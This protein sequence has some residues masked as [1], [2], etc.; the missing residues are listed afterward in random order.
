MSDDAAARREPDHV[1]VNGRS[2]AFP[3]DP[4]VVV[5]IDGSEPDYH[6]RAIAAGRMPYLESVLA[7]G[8]DLLADSVM[9]SFTNPNNLSIATGAPP[10]VHGICG[11][12]FFDAATRT[13]VMMNDPRFLRAPTIFS[14]FEQAGVDVAVVTA[15]DK[16]R[17]L[18][19][20]G[21]KTGICFSAE[22]ADSVTVEENGIADALSLTGRPLPSVY[23]A[24]LSEFAM[25]AG[26]E[27]MRTRRPGL[28]YLSLT[29]Y[30]QHKFAPGT[31]E[32]DDFY[33]MLDGYFAQLG[34]L[35]AV[36]AITGDHGMNAKSAPD[37]S[38]QVVYLQE[39]LDEWLGAGQSHVVLPITDPY[40]THHASLGS[41]AFV[42]LDDAGDAA[43]IQPRLAALAGVEDVIDRDE[44]CARYELPSDRIGDLA[45][46]GERHV[47]LGTS[48]D[49]HDLSK[50]D[51][52]LRSHGGRTEQVVPMIVN[53]V[54]N[55]LPHGHRLR[56]FDAYWLALN[57]VVR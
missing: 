39:H 1:E 24:D 50:L 51:R 3:T 32:A 6:L 16:L 17:R 15:K 52:P 26:V 13:D 2:Y 30:I 38:P 33:G 54:L 14:T 41:F 4:V 56:N 55:P 37:G 45:V 11:N 47:A 5:C 8:T 18:L 29:D 46:V 28:M 25:A 23:S 35:G 36:L 19:G 44:A 43:T 20:D 57:L 34:E 42:H 9:P 49:Q 27:L 53:R 40:T 7:E 48:R 31:P 22:K 12:Y 10:S 21:L